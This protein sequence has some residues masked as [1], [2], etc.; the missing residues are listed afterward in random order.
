MTGRLPT[1]PV[2]AGGVIA[3]LMV[4]MVGTV[5]EEADAR[6]RFKKVV[7]SFRNPTE[8]VIPDEGQANPYPSEIN[9]F[10]FK[11]GVVRDVNLIFWGYSHTFPEDVDVLLVHRGQSRTVMSDAG[12]LNNDVS[13]VNVIL[14]DE[15]V[16]VLPDNDPISTN[17]W[18]PKNYEGIDSFPAPA[19]N[20]PNPQELLSGF[21]GANPNGTWALYVYDEGRPDPGEF[22]GGWTIQIS[23][24]VRR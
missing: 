5:P 18:K 6:G 2:L 19:P 15:A 14:D 21:D 3:V 10:G 22:E 4:V 17:A 20:P 23:A 13:G 24:R 1:L 12:G 9:A 8:I 7:K 16:P 11:R